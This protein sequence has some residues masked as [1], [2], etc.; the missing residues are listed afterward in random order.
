VARGERGLL[1]HVD[2]ANWESISFLQTHDI[3]RAAGN[4]FEVL[5]RAVGAEVRGC[6]ALA[7]TGSGPAATEQEP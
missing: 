4:G 3:G 7:R 2:L 5:G 6:S 1:R